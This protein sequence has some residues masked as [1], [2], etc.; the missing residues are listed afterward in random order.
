MYVVLFFSFPLPFPIAVRA[1]KQVGRSRRRGVRV[2]CIQREVKEAG[3][4]ENGKK[5]APF[6]FSPFSSFLHRRLREEDEIGD[7]KFK[8]RK[9]WR[10]RERERERE[11]KRRKRRIRFADGEI[12][13][14]VVGM[15]RRKKRRANEGCMLATAV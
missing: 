13:A 5:G 1:K 11:R 12:R 10:E 15:R 2:C 4:E 14:F 9:E 7:G 6:R 8:E 3:E